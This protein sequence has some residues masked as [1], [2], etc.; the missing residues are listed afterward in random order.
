MTKK[1]CSGIKLDKKASASLL[2]AR[3]L[4]HSKRAR[5]NE[6]VI[7]ALKRGSEFVEEGDRS[8]IEE[9]IR[10]YKYKL[11][12]NIQARD[13]LETKNPDVFGYLHDTKDTRARE[14]VTPS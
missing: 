6:M 7:F 3:R 5:A 1:A 4:Y 8:A 13:L 14:Q 12:Q 11:S 10:F 2:S 9:A